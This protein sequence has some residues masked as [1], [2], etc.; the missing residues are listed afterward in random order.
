MSKF[1]EQSWDREDLVGLLPSIVP[2]LGSSE[3]GNESVVSKNERR[4]YS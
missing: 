3:R 4:E 1:L 2:L